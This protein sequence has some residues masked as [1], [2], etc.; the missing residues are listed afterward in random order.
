MS[1]ELAPLKNLLKDL[2][3]QFVD[4]GGTVLVSTHTLE[5]A[6]AVCDRIAII[7]GGHIIASGTLD[8]LRHRTAEGRLSLEEVF[9]RLTGGPTARELDVI[10]GE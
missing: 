6:E 8:E 10:L 7:Q 2:F 5:V 9:L 3:R 4:R 1:D